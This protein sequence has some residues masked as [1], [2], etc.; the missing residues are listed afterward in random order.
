MA[1][2]GKNDLTQWGLWYSSREKAHKIEV[3]RNERVE[4]SPELQKGN[5]QERQRE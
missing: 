3:R 2:N 4:E 5:G 1:F